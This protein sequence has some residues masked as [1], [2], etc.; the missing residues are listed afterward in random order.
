MSDVM[1][2]SGVIGLGIFC[3]LDVDN[4]GRT[5]Q[6]IRCHPDKTRSLLSRVSTRTDVHSKC[7]FRVRK[8]R[9]HT[10]PFPF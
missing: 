3:L 5:E 10:K 4:F 7:N 2:E 8:K 1:R 6:S 9:R